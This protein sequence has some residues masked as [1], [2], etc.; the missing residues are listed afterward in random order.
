MRVPL[1]AAALLLGASAA[2]A[3]D[4]LVSV[5]S[6]NTPKETLDRFEAVAKSKG[7][8]INAR[9]AGRLRQAGHRQVAP[10]PGPRGTARSSPRA[11]LTK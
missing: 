2:T 10:W 11:T 6:A 9:R 3:A 5:R 4:G 1:I 8:K 7:M